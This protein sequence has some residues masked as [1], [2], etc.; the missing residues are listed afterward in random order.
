MN[1]HVYIFMW[2]YTFISLGV[3]IPRNK[4]TGSYGN[5]IFNILKKSQTWL[6][7]A[8]DIS[9]SGKLGFQFLHIL[10]IIKVVSHGFDLHFPVG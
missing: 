9:I 6:K 8:T 1:I 3:Y 2:A 5:S 7:A 10:A 4:I